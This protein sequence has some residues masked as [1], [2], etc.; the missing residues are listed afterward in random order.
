M[1]RARIG[2]VTCVHPLYDLPA[3][4]VWRENAIGE[5]RK[6]GSEVIAAAIP[7]TTADAIGIAADLAGREVDL[8]VLFFCSWVSEDITLA[9]AREIGDIPM[10]LWALPYLDRDIPMPSPMSGLTGSGSNIRRM[11]KPFAYVIGNVTAAIVEEVVRAAGAGAA[12]RALRCARLGVVGDPCPGMA[13]VVVDEAALQQALGVST[14]HFELDVLVRAAETASRGEAERAAE[15]L[16]AAT[17]GRRE[18]SQQALA[19]NLRL[20]VA[21]RELVRTNRLDAYCVRCW[22]ELRNQHGITPCAAHALMAQE[23]IASTCEVDVTALV[24]TWLLSRLAGAPAFNFDITGY[25]EPEDAIQLAHC[26]AAEPSLAGDPGKALL[27]VHMRTA[28][29]ATVEFPFKE[30]AVTVAKLLRPADGRLRLFAARGEVIPTEE[31]V[32]G[33]V[34]TVRPAPSAEAFLSAVM[35]EGVEHHVA[36]VYGDWRRDL[37]LFCEFTAVEYVPLPERR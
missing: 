5:L 37:E 7:R 34:A 25:L 24:T 33:S 32:R 26:G 36:L 35:R 20:Y 27:R 29:G 2:F 12:A 13:D 23:G 1:N 18:V 17:G 4:A 30:G 8:V 21:I 3:V 9:L 10:L 19:E 28:T 11:G 31:G 14:V 22:P 6:S 16:I 15:R